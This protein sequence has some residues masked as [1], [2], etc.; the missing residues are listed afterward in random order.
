MDQF[1][2]EIVRDG[3]RKRVLQC[4]ILFC[5]LRNRFQIPGSEDASDLEQAGESAKGYGSSNQSSLQ[6]SFGG[7]ADCLDSSGDFCEAKQNHLKD[8]S[9]SKNRL[10]KERK[11]GENHQIT[12]DFDQR[13][14]TCKNH[15]IQRNVV[16][17]GCL[18]RKVRS[19]VPVVNK[20][21]KKP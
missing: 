16:C 12:A 10:D 21:C 17:A 13:F 15:Q 9:E 14:H 3:Q 7:G 4:R 11:Y 2:D 6:A 20:T 5:V 1:P 8:R 19:A 18:K